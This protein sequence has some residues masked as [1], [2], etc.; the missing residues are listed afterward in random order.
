MA[1]LSGSQPWFLLFWFGCGSFVTAKLQGRQIS[2][3]SAFQVSSYSESNKFQIPNLKFQ[4]NSKFKVNKDSE[5]HLKVTSVMRLSRKQY[6]RIK[7][8]SAMIS[9]TLTFTDCQPESRQCNLFDFSLKPN[10]LQN[11]FTASR[12]PTLQ[13]IWAD[14]TQDTYLILY[15]IHNTTSIIRPWQDPNSK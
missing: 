7:W 6:G 3:P 10:D 4:I 5:L 2:F 12:I 13:V 11:R 9:V 14:S 1:G 8:K 15:P